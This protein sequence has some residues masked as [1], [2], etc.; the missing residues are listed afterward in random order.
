MPDAMRKPIRNAAHH[1]HPHGNPKYK[2]NLNGMLPL[3]GREGVESK[4][5]PLVAMEGLREVARKLLPYQQGSTY[6]KGWA[7]GIAP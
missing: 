1:R 3:R 6:E 4:V 2:G 5:R 7:V